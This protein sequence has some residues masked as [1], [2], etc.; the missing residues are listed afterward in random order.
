MK[1]SSFR[2]GVRER[3]DWQTVQLA[4]KDFGASGTILLPL[5]SLLPA[6]LQTWGRRYT[7]F[8]LQGKIRDT[9]RRKA[10][11]MLLFTPMTCSCQKLLKVY[12]SRNW[13]RQETEIRDIRITIQPLPGSELIWKS[14]WHTA[15]L[16]ILTAKVV[17][18][19]V[20][21]WKIRRLVIVYILQQQLP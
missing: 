4:Q 11:I 3:M 15:V 8:L 13:E 2:K 19:S 1:C 7:S 9:D 14:I 16:Q 6:S 10:I 21:F 5:F 17:I 12:L 18:L 20:N